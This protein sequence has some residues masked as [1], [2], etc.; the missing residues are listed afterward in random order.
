M[1]PQG[2]AELVNY[3]K[4]ISN[5]VV[6]FEST[7]PYSLLMYKVLQKHVPKEKILCINAY[8]AKALPGRKS[9]KIDSKNLAKYAFYGLLRGSYIPDTT[10]QILRRLTR[11][12]KRLKRMAA[13]SKNRIIM[14]L[15]RAG[16]RINQNIGLFTKYGLKL[17]IELAM[18][19][20]LKQY[21][22][23]SP[24]LREPN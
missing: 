12:R 15:D 10:Y 18:G 3:L 8:F 21:I 7:G 5:F 1:T 9:D 20:S 17:L 16:L 14:I 23:I 6:A 4:K 19:T 2:L 24:R 13:S 11:G 22:H